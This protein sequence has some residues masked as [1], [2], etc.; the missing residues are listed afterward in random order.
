MDYAAAEKII[1]D[2]IRPRSQPIGARFLKK[3]EPF[4]EKTKRPAALFKK[5]I[6]ICQGI[7][8][9]RTYG[10]GI[11]LSKEDLICVPGIVAWGMS[12]AE[13]PTDELAGLFEAVEFAKDE[14]VAKSHAQSLLCPAP[15]EVGG[16]LLEPLSK[17]DQTPDT[18]VIYCNPAQ[19]MRLIQGIS[20]TRPGE[21][22]GSFGGKVECIDL[23]YSSYKAGEPRV[24]IPGLGDRIF[25][26]T[27]DDE[28][29][30][31]LPGELLPDL[32]EGLSK[33]AKKIGGQYPVTFYQN[34][35]P[36]FPP[37]HRELGEKLKLFS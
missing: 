26:M 1:T 20:Y 35:E 6:T 27:Q 17:V 11:G 24:A 33:A 23:L 15:G 7:T 3:R 13:N 36:R 16:I 28:L 9:A 14:T 25:S 4:P 5:R 12:G 18:I 10:W 22:G 29:A 34:F 32:L 19:V 8:L 31:T 2:A 37:A 21:V 30:L